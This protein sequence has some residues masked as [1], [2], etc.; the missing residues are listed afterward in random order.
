[1]ATKAKIDYEIEIVPTDGT[2]SALGLKRRLLSGRR[3][4]G[5]SQSIC[6]TERE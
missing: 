5:S 4:F 6:L 1:M 3:C 2:K